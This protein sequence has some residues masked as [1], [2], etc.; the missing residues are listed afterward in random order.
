MDQLI[1]QLEFE[2][3][4]ANVRPLRLYIALSTLF[5]GRWGEGG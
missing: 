5:F 1:H 4:L 3:R 2:T